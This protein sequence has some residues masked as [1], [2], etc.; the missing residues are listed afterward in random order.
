[1]KRATSGIV[2]QIEALRRRFESGELKPAVCADKAKAAEL[3]DRQRRHAAQIAKLPTTAVK[4][5]RSVMA[6]DME[7]SLAWNELSRAVQ[8]DPAGVLMVGGTGAGKTTAMVGYALS[9]ISTGSTVEY[10]KAGSYAVVVKSES[11]TARLEA[12][13]LVLLDQFHQ[14]C[15]LPDWIKEPFIDLIVGRID[16]GKQIIASSTEGIGTLGHEDALRA[17][18]VDR[19]TVRLGTDESS[20]RR[21]K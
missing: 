19:F 10:A 18:T 21:T 8:S 5:A 16:N 1:M 2:A 20:Y 17:E 15:H 11:L 14:A 4:A 6:G 9:R 13:D 12:A 7:R 3:A